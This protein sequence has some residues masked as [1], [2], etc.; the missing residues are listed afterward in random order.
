MVRSH[1]E[2]ADLQNRLDELLHGG[3]PDIAAAVELL[4]RQGLEARASDIVLEPG[5]TQ[6][7]VRIRVDGVMQTIARVPR[8]VLPNLV[9]R[10]KVLAGLLYEEW[11]RASMANLRHGV[12]QLT[13]GDRQQAFYQ[14]TA[15][16]EN[17]RHKMSRGLEYADYAFEIIADYG[18]YRDLHRHR[19]LTHQRQPVGCVLSAGATFGFMRPPELDRPEWQTISEKYDAAMHQAKDAWTVLSSHVDAEVAQY[20]VP[21]AYNIR[22]VMKANLR[23]WVWIVELR[24]QPGGHPNYRKICQEIYQEIIR[25][26]PSFEA[27]FKF[28][29]MEGYDLGRS[30]AEQRQESKS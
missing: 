14:M 4:L 9:N 22:W 29:D 7:D 23:E 8:S 26:H 24:T 11:G 6:V 19:V 25:V 30:Q 5:E 12:D 1:I 21:L 13:I 27:F 18:V 17:R 16:R 2:S 10:I 20:V 3:T 15:G 28:A